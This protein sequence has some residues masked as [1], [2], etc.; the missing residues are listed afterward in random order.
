MDRSRFWAALPAVTVYCA[1]PRELLNDIYKVLEIKK[2]DLAEKKWEKY[3]EYIW[4]LKESKF[5]I[6]NN[7]DWLGKL[8][9]VDFNKIGRNISVN[10]LLSKETIK[11]RVENPKSSLSFLAFSYS[12]LQAYDFYYLYQNYNCHGQLGGSDQWGNLTTG[13]ELIRKNCSKELL[14]EFLFQKVRA[15]DESKNDSKH[16]EKTS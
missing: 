4:P 11:Q 1:W 5:R 2:G 14:P 15:I 10:Y 9:I 12:L 13:L 3:L 16:C 7:D 8:S 6:L